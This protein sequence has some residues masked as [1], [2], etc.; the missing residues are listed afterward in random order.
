MDQNCKVIMLLDANLYLL[1]DT[2]CGFVPS[3]ILLDKSLRGVRN[4]LRYL[5]IADAWYAV[6]FL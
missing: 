3:F 5:H 2:D 1:Y 6:L 4:N